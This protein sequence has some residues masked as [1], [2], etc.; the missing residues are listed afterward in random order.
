[1]GANFC[2]AETDFGSECQ[3]LSQRRDQFHGFAS[4][5]V[6]S[7]I[8]WKCRPHFRSEKP[9]SSGNADQYQR[10]RNGHSLRAHCPRALSPTLLSSAALGTA[11][12]TETQSQIAWDGRIRSRRSALH[13]VQGSRG[14]QLDAWLA[15][16]GAKK[17]CRPPLIHLV[18][19][20]C[21]TAISERIQFETCA[22]SS[23]PSRWRRNPNR[24]PM[25]SI[26]L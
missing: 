5:G 20:S 23:R 8:R 12:T 21:T 1:M 2:P 24:G 4:A 7:G 22:F 15:E 14:P 26:S 17:W 9:R 3:T 19:N 10:G 18:P 6:I 13:D 16:Q 25:L 11:T